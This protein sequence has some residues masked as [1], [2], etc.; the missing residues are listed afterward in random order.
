MFESALVEAS[1]LV[2]LW[3]VFITNLAPILVHIFWVRLRTLKCGDLLVRLFSSVSRSA[4]L[5]SLRCCELFQEVCVDLKG[6]YP[7]LRKD[8]VVGEPFQDFELV[9]HGVVHFLFSLPIVVLLASLVVS[10]HCFRFSFRV[11]VGSTHILNTCWYSC[12]PR[13]LPAFCLF[14][15]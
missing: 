9:Q 6:A 12:G 3:C 14:L 13:R 5:R 7:R 11:A 10:C 15:C 8:L 4:G 2:V 1:C